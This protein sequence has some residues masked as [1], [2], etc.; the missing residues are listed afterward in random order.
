MKKST[1]SKVMERLGSVTLFILVL[2]LATAQSAAAAPLAAEVSIIWPVLERVIVIAGAAV[3][4]S[5]WQRWR[6]RRNKK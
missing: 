1:R 3:L 6:E 4:I 2:V 5:V